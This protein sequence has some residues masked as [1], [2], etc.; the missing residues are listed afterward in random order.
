MGQRPAGTNCGQPANKNE[1]P[2]GVFLLAE[3]NTKRP[4]LGYTT[5]MRYVAL[6]RGIMPTNPN[7]KGEKLKAVFE[8]LGFSN[9]HTVIAS[10]NV[11]TIK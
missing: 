1:T 9:V 8:G 5:S 11:E 10:G 6:L 4:P 7:M 2:Q 3:S